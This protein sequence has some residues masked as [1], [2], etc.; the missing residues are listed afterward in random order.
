[1]ER[2]LAILYVADEHEVLLADWNWL[3]P[4]EMQPLLIGVF[5]DWVFVDQDRSYW[6]LDLLEGKFVKI[7]QD[8]KDFNSRKNQRAFQ[9]EWFGANWAEIAFG[10]GLIPARDECLGWKVA[11]LIGG[12]F[13]LENI[14]VF[15]LRVYQR[16]HSGLLRKTMKTPRFWQKLWR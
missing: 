8:T 2:D 12:E 7:A 3:I 14:D 11:P 15:P 13:A 9:D 4:K 5:G 1:M 16:V 6:H 10:A